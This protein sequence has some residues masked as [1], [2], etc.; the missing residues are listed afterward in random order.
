MNPY[1][2]SHTSYLLLFIT[3]AEEVGAGWCSG[4]PLLPTCALKLDAR[5]VA[6]PAGKWMAFHSERSNGWLVFPGVYVQ[7]AVLL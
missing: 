6:E 5:L 2:L 4:L 1:D 3:W 7:P